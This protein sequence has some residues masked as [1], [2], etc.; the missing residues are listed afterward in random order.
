VAAASVPSRVAVAVAAANAPSRAAAEAAAIA[1][2]ATPTAVA[3]AVAVA[4]VVAAAIGKGFKGAPELKRD[5]NGVTLQT[6]SWSVLATVA[7]RPGV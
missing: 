1:A 3:V 4:A 5:S 6:F 7:T 2:S